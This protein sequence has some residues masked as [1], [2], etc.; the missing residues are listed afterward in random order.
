M[1]LNTYLITGGTAGIGLAT[2]KQLVQQGHH[3]VIT[4]RNAEKLEKVAAG[5]SGDVTAILCDSERHEDTLALGKRLQEKG[6]QLDGVVL[7]AGVYFPNPFDSTT[8]DEFEHT[9]NINFKAPFFTLQ[10]LLP[11]LKL[12][13][14][15][16]MV[17]SLVVNKAFADSS[18]YTASKAALEGLVATLNL[19]LADRGIRINS[20]RPG[21]TA[22]EIQKKAGMSAEGFGELQEAM[23]STPLGRILEVSDIVPSIEFLLSK[24]SLGM[25]NAVL[26]I[27]A[28]LG[29]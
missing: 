29:L 6:I 14:S 19:D 10:S 1:G 9:M 18:I 7:N 26:D 20:V 16:V 12:S 23:T 8:L 17:S 5:L 15:V 24:G 4:G 11:V 2:A 3:V 28:G 25:R 22:T 21:V 27:D 13:S